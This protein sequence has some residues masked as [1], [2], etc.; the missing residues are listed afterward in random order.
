MRAAFLLIPFAALGALATAGG[1]DVSGNGSMESM[2]SA[3][4]AADAAEAAADELA[5][6]VTEAAPG[7]PAWLS[8]RTYL[9]A[10]ESGDGAIWYFEGLDS[11]FSV[12]PHRV[13]L[14][15]DESRVAGS[16]HD[17]SERLAEIDCAAH[18]YR[19][20]RTTHYNRAGRASEA[21]ERGDGSLVPVPPGS[22]FAAVEETV[23]GHAQRHYGADAD[24][25]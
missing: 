11:E 6:N 21:N 1:Q 20:L 18:R 10:G 23:C 24:A 22:V 19:I 2:D 16:P 14:R 4:M 25:R 12:R 17:N 7:R 3:E 9:W 13:L 8:G 15:T 5:G